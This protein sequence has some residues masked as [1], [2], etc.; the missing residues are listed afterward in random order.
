MIEIGNKI[1]YLAEAF[2]LSQPSSKLFWG[3]SGSR[4]ANKG[5][6][7]D[8]SPWGVFNNILWIMFLKRIGLRP[9][10]CHN[11]ISLVILTRAT[12]GAWNWEFEFSKWSLLSFSAIRTPS[13]IYLSSGFLNVFSTFILNTEISLIL[14]G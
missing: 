2:R 11:P 10:S 7:S 6:G 14:S 8:V 13:Y 1:K 5:S 9:I 12:A 4:F 3:E